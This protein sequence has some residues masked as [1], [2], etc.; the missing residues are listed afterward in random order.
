MKQMLTL[1]T[2]LAL[3]CFLVACGGGEKAEKSAMPKKKTAMAPAGYMAGTVTD[4]GSITGKVTYAGSAPEKKMLE[5]TKDVNVC[6]KATHF[7]ESVVV[8]DGGGLANV[9]VH[10][11]NISKGKGMEA[12]GEAVLDQHG[13]AFVPH[14]S[15]VA[16]GAELTILNSDGVL[17]NIHTYGEKNKPVNVAQPGFKKKMKQTFSEE[18]VFRIACDVHNWMGG[19]VAVAGHPYYAV[20][21]ED[22]SFEL[23]DVPAGTYTVE[24]WQESLGKQTVEVTVTAGAAA[25]ANMEF[26]SGS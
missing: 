3:A 6:G 7:D 16:A 8:G 15:V 10:I 18:E 17:H 20:T 23:K 9:V 19:W 22:G 21:G 25:E 5:I 26:S 12:L 11:T 14:V 1:I 24:F 4:G 13:C 2:V